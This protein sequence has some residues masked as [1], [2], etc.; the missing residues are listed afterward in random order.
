[1]FLKGLLDLAPA[2]VREAVLERT[3]VGSFSSVGYSVRSDAWAEVPSM[4]GAT[5][6]VTGGSSGIGR[7]ASTMMLELG[8]RVFVTSRSRERAEHSARELS[9][10]G[11]AVGLALDTGSEES[12]RAFADELSAKAGEIDVLLSNAGA[13]SETYQTASWGLEQT[14]ASHLVG[15]YLLMG[16][17]KSTM[18]SGGRMVLMASGG[19]YSQPLKMDRLNMTAADYKGAVAYARA[20]RAQVELAAYLGPRWAPDVLVHAV[21]PGWVDTP[22]VDAA[23]PGFSRVVGPILRT[24]QQG[25]DTAVWLAA[26]GGIDGP[27]GSFWHDRAVRGTN[28]LPG[29]RATDSERAELVEW[30]EATTGISADA[31]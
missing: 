6:V 11:A 20:K 16:L 3:I 27:P 1:M 22:G 17:I 31:D 13:L 2:G 24:P 19:M 7:A 14:L 8:A 26:T 30:L 21:H 29:T 28:Y 18:V 4:D 12:I 25:A 5:V 10:D 23:L 9:P 15:P